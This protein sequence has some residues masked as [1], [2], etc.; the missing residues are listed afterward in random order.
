[1]PELI[2]TLHAEELRVAVMDNMVD[3]VLTIDGDGVLEHM[4]RAAVRM[5]GWT[6]GELY[7]RFMHTTV[8]RQ[9]ADGSPI[10]AAECPLL[11]AL[12]SGRT[13]R[14]EEDVFTR[15]DG[16]TFRVSC[17][18]APVHVGDEVRGLVVVFRDITEE[19]AGRR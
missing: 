2:K 7:G 14:M 5:L 10:S 12:R 13:V 18:F 3:G 4:N 15:A 6:E 1:M 8:R 17:S 9:R 19:A 11:E 16:S